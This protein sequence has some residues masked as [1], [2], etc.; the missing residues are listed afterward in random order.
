[1]ATNWTAHSAFTTKQTGRRVEPNNV[2]AYIASLALIVAIWALLQRIFSGRDKEF[3]DSVISL[4]KNF[5]DRMAGMQKAW[6]QGVQEARRSAYDQ[7]NRI[8]AEC[9]TNASNLRI[10][11][12]EIMERLSAYPTKDDFK[13]VLESALEPVREEQQ[14]LRTFMEE[15]LRAGVLEQRRQ[16]DRNDR[17]VR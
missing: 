17:N 14:R 11:E 6:Q 3:R 15:V 4:Q 1:M 5:D 16:N 8:S 10:L 12:R 13:S 9:T 7:F 2:S